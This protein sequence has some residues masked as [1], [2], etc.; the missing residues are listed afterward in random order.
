[1][2]LVLPLVFSCP[3]ASK[4]WVAVPTVVGLLAAS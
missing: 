4:A 2:K 1:V 3:A